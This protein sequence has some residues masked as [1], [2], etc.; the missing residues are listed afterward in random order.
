[1]G[2]GGERGVQTTSIGLQEQEQGGQ[3]NHP[4]LPLPIPLP[5]EGF[6]PVPVQK[7]KEIAKLKTGCSLLLECFAPSLCTFLVTL[8]DF[9]FFLRVILVADWLN[10]LKF[11]KI[12]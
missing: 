1:V 12:G 5:G 4:V 11:F 9:S 8:S 2:G 7:E 3:Q 10:L 6:S